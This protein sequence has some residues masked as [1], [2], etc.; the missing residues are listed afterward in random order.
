MSTIP[1][2]KMSDPEPAWDVA[3][4]FPPQ[5]QWT[6]FEYLSLTETTNKLVELTDGDIRVL[7]MPTTAHQL[8]VQFLLDV[9]RA[10]IQPKGLGLVLFAPLRVKIRNRKFREPDL[11]FM[12]AEHADRMGNE[13]WIGADLVVEIVSNS[14]EGRHRDL[15]EKRGDYAEAGVPEYWIVDPME[16]M[17]SV[18]ELEDGRYVTLGEFKVGEIASSKLLPGLAIDVAATFKVA[19]RFLGD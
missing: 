8:I 14:K 17:I 19:H 16:K 13:Y 5:G 4:L 12:L 11:V 15:Q 2:A 7:E 18:L 9:F 1:Y 10:F 3:K 6:E